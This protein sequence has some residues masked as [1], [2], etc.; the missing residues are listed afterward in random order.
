MPK[1]AVSLTLEEANLLW[2][3]GRTAALGRASLSE[4][5]DRLITEARAGKFGQPQPTRSVVGTVDIAEDDPELER[6]DAAV[7]ELFE[8]SIQRPL[9]VREAKSSYAGAPRRKTR[10]R[11]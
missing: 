6:A 2:L 1:S 3:R 9:V 7:R 11:G 8:R 4:T 5:V 10:R